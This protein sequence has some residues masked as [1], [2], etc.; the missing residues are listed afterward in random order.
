MN[1]TTFTNSKDFIDWIVK[2]LND[3]NANEAGKAFEEYTKRWHI[4][5]GDYLHVFDANDIH[6]IPSVYLDK[7]DAWEL[8]NK[9]ANSFGID[10]VCVT[11]FHEI[12][13]HQDKSSLNTDKNLS[14][15]KAEGMMSLRNNPLK[16]V[17]NFVVNTTAQDLS[18]YKNVWKDQPPLTFG[19]DAFVPD[20]NDVEE[21]EKDKLF[22]QNIQ[23]ETEGKPTVDIYKF[24]SRGL[25]QDTYI[26]A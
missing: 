12:D 24:K 4:A 8:L 20:D 13:V 23:A 14:A 25:E 16:N 7:L 2:E 19:Y 22:W 26:L 10:K 6:A 17:R 3:G 1:W 21:I 15:K 9:G 5:F 11:R 18:H